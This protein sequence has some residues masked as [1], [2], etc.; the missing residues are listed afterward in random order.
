MTT[1]LAVG[2]YALAPQRCAVRFTARGFGLRVPG[3]MSVRSGEVRVDGAGAVVTAVLDAASFRTR[4]PRR[5]RDVRSAGFLDVEQHPDILLSGRWDG[6]GT[7]L[8]A[9][10]TV[11][12]VAAPVDIEIV[13]VARSPHGARAAARARVDRRAFPVGPVRGPVGRWIDVELDLELDV[14]R[15][16]V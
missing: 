12:G 16:D 9:T 6:P 2:R 14:E 4:T 15:D 8:R 1:A 10:L 7:A 13:D 3:E 5:D 11:K